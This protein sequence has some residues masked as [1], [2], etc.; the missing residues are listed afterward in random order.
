MG[1]SRA[2][3][4]QGSM[5]AFLKEPREQDRARGASGFPGTIIARKRSK[6]VRQGSPQRAQNGTSPFPPRLPCVGTPDIF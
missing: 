4:Y 3:G 5:G 2:S 1:M 6:Y